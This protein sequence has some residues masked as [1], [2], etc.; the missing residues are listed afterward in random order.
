MILNFF[1]RKISHSSGNLD[2]IIKNAVSR[3]VSRCHVVHSGRRFR[4][5][6]IAPANEVMKR[7]SRNSRPNGAT[8]QNTANF[9]LEALVTSNLTFTNRPLSAS[10]GTHSSGAARDLW[11]SGTASGVLSVLSWVLRTVTYARN[12]F[13]TCFFYAVVKVF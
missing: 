7:G 13:S 6:F 5:N 3:N 4:G 1:P 9:I 2:E 8:F 11:F 10:R 12:L